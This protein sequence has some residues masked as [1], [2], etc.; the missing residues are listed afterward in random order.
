MSDPRYK[1]CHV[2]NFL[3]RDFRNWLLTSSQIERETGRAPKETAGCLRG[4]LVQPVAK[5]QL[6]LGQV[7]SHSS[8]DPFP[9]DLKESVSSSRSGRQQMS[10]PRY[11]PCYV[12]KLIKKDFKSRLLTSSQRQVERQKRGQ[13]LGTHPAMS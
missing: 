12:K 9:S 6:V 13:T 4:L 3:K 2:K 8:F 11:K 7:L 5:S 1:P 10:D